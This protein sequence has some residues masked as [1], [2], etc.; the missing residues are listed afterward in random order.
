MLRICFLYYVITI[1]DNVLSF[2][3]SFNE[4]PPLNLLLDGKG[5]HG[6]HAH[7]IGTG[8]TAAHQRCV[9]GIE[10]SM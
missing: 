3:C 1:G 6:M 8:E 5:Y 2:G 7:T 10:S 4:I 9:L